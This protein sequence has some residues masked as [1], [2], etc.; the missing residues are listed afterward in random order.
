MNTRDWMNTGTD[1]FLDHLDTLADEQFAEPSA[2]PGWNRAHVIAHV[3][4]NAQALRRL[5]HWA[6]TGEH[7]PMY[8]STE[9]RNNEIAD[10]ATLPP[11]KLRTLV[12]ESADALNT[13]CDTLPEQCWQH[14][15][16]TAQGRTVPA[17][18]ILWMRTREVAVH[19][20]DLNT[21]AAFTN[22]PD[23]L[24]TALTTDAAAKHCRTGN[25]ATLAEWL[26]GRAAAAPQLGPWL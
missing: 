3:H 9:Q 13:D 16:V 20:I 6:R 12:R 19:A 10:G 4:Y 23:E 26:T 14:E 2:L 22:L 1:L 5:L 17:S 8:D 18:E 11:E 15:I 21:G 25:A 7:T 24:N